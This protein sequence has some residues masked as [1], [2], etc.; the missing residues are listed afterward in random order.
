MSAE[1]W[2]GKGLKKRM[3]SIIVPVYNVREYL[4]E[5]LD[6]ILQQSYRKL[7]IIIVDDGSTDGSS[8]I[9][10]SYAH[11]DS[12]IIVIHQSNQ[13]LSGA[14]NTGLDHIHGEW[15]AFVDSDDIIDIRMYETMHSY[16]ERYSSEMVVCGVQ[17]FRAVNREKMIEGQIRAAESPA[18]CAE[19]EY[20]KNYDRGG[21]TIY[22]VVWNKLYK[23]S[24]W[25]D[26]RF[27]EGKYCEDVF[28]MHHIV[29]R[30]RKICLIPDVFCWYRLRS[31]S[32][33]HEKYNEKHLD[34]VE[35]LLAR[36]SFFDERQLYPEERIMLRSAVYRLSEAGRRLPAKDRKKGSV[37]ACLST[38]CK[39]QCIF[40]LRHGTDIRF[41]SSSLPFMLG[42]GIYR[43]IKTI[44]NKVRD[45]R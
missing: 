39:R 28:V 2:K 30:C 41:I 11:K 34:A 16:A 13:G 20:W 44:R 27:P 21:S 15:I 32:I 19:K 37:Y 4:E 24:L 6:S 26:V 10:D 12:R 14:R 22:D 36:S 43:G 35:A 23:S 5:C 31:S 3:L 8:E 1:S 7:E 9:C 45:I 40:S 33:M 18:V 29:S 42:P 25:K 38:L 17:S